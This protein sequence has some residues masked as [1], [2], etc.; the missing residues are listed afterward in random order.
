MEKKYLTARK[1]RKNSTQQ[2]D[3]LWNL[4]RNRNLSN[5][6]FIRQYPIGPYIVDFAARKQ[7]LVIEIDGGQHNMPENIE[8]DL[9]RTQYIEAKGYKVIRFWN[10]EID[11]NLEGVYLKILEI[12][13]NK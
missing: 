12:I 8:D 2:E 6:K 4:L 9:K 1:L 11:D 10:N 13:K 5:I 3:K 7:R